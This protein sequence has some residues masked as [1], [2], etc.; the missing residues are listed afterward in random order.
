MK[1]RNKLTIFCIQNDSPSMLTSIFTFNNEFIQILI[2]EMFEYTQIPFFQIL[3]SFVQFNEF[4][5]AIRT[6]V[7][8]TLL[9]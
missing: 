2:L 9:K 5:V 4:S 6:Y 3:D 7:H 1:K 8:R